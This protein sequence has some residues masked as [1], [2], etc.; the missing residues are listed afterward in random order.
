[1]KRVLLGV[2][3]L[4][5]IA[6]GCAGM[7]DAIG[8]LAEP[9]VPL[10]EPVAP[11]A[12]APSPASLDGRWCEENPEVGCYRFEGFAVHEE[13][14]KLKNGTKHAAEGTWTM[15]GGMLLMRFPSGTWTLEVLKR[16]DNILIVKDYS[17]DQTFTFVRR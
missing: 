14:V 8:D 5:V 10:V 3:M 11:A 15:E 9:D 7:P 12:E 6:C 2:S 16:T 17:Q 4:F 13:A 1:M